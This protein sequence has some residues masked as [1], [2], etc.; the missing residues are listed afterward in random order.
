MSGDTHSLNCRIY[1]QY[2]LDERLEDCIYRTLRLI[3]KMIQTNNMETLLRTY[4]FKTLMLWACEQRPADMW[5]EARLVSTVQELLM[6][7]VEWLNARRCLN[8]FISANNMI[9]HLVNVNVSL[10]I[11]NLRAA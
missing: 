4:Y 8:Y 2:Q 10:D 9:D 1:Y 6:E 7:M 3:Y 5:T 11:N